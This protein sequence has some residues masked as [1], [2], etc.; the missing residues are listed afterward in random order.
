MLRE[1]GAAEVHL[2]ISSPPWRWPCFYGIDTPSLRGAAGDRTTPSRRWRGCSAPTRW[3][4]SASRTS[5]RPSGRTAGFCDACFTGD[6]P[7]PVP[8]TAT[9][10]SIGPRPS[11]RRPGPPGRAARGLSAVGPGRR[12]L[13]RRRRRHRG[14]R[15][16]RR[17][18]ARH[19]GG[20]RRLR[21][22][23][24]PRHRALRRAGARGVDRRRRAPSSRWRGRPAATTPSASTWWPCASTTSS[25][26]AP[27][28]CSSSTTSPPAR[29]TPTGSPPSWPA[30]TRAAGRP[31]AR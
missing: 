26:S 25:A 27:S 29:S 13:R 31:A 11:G 15:R 3:P 4:T 2:R 19:G 30:S 9:P 1:A 24:P 28:R 23:V 8:A 17:A 10:V 20:H 16:R 21:R 7:T 5:R 12:H 22:P 14:R 18:P 6:Y